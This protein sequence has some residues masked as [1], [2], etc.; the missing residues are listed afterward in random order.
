MTDCKQLGLGK[1]PVLR[2]AAWNISGYGRNREDAQRLL[3]SGEADILFLS[4]TKQT[5]VDALL[6]SEG[7][8]IIMPARRVKVLPTMGIAFFISSVW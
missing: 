4:E 5:A 2:L 6:E 1:R 3:D 7:Q 8:S